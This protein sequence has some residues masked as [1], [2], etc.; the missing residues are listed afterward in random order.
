[1]TLAKQHFEDYE[2]LTQY[3]VDLNNAYLSAKSYL[4][5]EN[6][7]SHLLG[8]VFDCSG[9]Q[10][11]HKSF[12]CS[13]ENAEAYGGLL[14]DK[15]RYTRY[16]LAVN[17]CQ[18]QRSQCGAGYPDTCKAP[19]PDY[20]LPCP[21]RQIRPAISCQKWQHTDRRNLLIWSFR[22]WQLSPRV[23]VKTVQRWTWW[24]LPTISTFSPRFQWL[25]L[26]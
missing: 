6:A 20:K 18:P 12:E 25:P 17:Y 24:S 1:M 22:S 3:I 11:W 4:G 2:V 14:R 21:I 7:N 16:C 23:C 8:M 5:C 9:A 13:P 10:C 19:A 26:N 15:Q